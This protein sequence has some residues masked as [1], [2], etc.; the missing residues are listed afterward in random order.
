MVDRSGGEALEADI[1]AVVS[2]YPQVLGIDLLRSRTFGRRVYV[3]LE[4]RMPGKA[5]LEDSHAVAEAIHDALEARFPR[6]KHV[7]I[8]IN[9]A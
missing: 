5:T 3:D 6:I 4:I 9:P 8:H 2:G 1:R 7:M